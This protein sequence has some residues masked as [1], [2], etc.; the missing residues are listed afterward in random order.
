[1]GISERKALQLR[2]AIHFYSNMK[3]Q[4][5]ELFF[6]APSG[7]RKEK[8]RTTL[9]P[10]VSAQKAY[11]NQKSLKEFANTELNKGNPVKELLI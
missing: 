7:K 1:M 10:E 5:L 4:L 3:W 6:L 8:K 2:E 9:K 11:S